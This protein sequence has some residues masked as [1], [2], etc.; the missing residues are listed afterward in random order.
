MLSKGLKAALQSRKAAVDA[1]ASTSEATGDG[2][3]FSASA[4]SFT[5]ARSHGF[6]GLSNLGAT[7]YMNSLLQA[8]FCQANVR[9][10]VLQFAFDEHVQGE[11]KRCVLRQLQWLFS[12]LLLS[13]SAAISTLPLTKSFGWDSSEAFVQND[14]H[15]CLNVLLEAIAREDATVG[16][17]LRDN[18][19]GLL[20]HYIQCEGCGT[21]RTRPEEFTTF[22]IPVKGCADV[23]AALH[24]ALSEEVLSGDNAYS[25][26]TCGSKQ[27][28]RK[29][30]RLPAA[31]LPPT[32]FLHLNR[33]EFDFSTMM[34]RKIQDPIVPALLL[35]M[36]AHA[37]PAAEPTDDASSTSPDSLVYEL[38]G[39]LMHVGSAMS[40]HYFAY[41]RVPAEGGSGEAGSAVSGGGTRWLSFN[42]SI[43]TEL[44][45]DQLARA[46]GQRS[47]AGS[48]SAPASNGPSSLPS[49]F[50]AGTVS[51]GSSGAYLLIYRR[52]DKLSS[53]FE[54]VTASSVPA[55]IRSLIEAENERILEAAA[56]WE[57]EKRKLRF[58]V[59][60][61]G[62]LAA[63]AASTLSSAPSS[64]SP[65]AP[66]PV[67]AAPAI[68]GPRPTMGPR[69]GG[70][71]AV[72]IGSARP[73]LPQPPRPSGPPT[74]PRPPSRPSATA[75]GRGSVAPSVEVV[76]DKEGDASALL[77]AAVIAATG[78]TDIAESELALYCLRQYDV[79]QGVPLQPVIT[80]CSD[81]CTSPLLGLPP[82]FSS[83]PPS[84][85]TDALSRPRA[86]CLEKRASADVAWEAWEG[87]PVPVRVVLV[88]RNGQ[89]QV[90]PV[91]KS[92]GT[93]PLDGFSFS[94]PLLL[95]LRPS[96]ATVGGLRRAVA[97]SQAPAVDVTRLLLAVL[98][99]SSDKSG[100]V[101]SDDSASLLPPSSAS[102][103]AASTAT[104]V[105]ADGAI[106]HAESGGG[107]DGSSSALLHAWEASLHC[108]NVTCIP[109]SASSTS[110][111][112]HQLAPLQVVIDDRQPVTSL[113]EM[114]SEAYGLSPRSFKL[115]RQPPS[116]VPGDSSGCSSSTVPVGELK[117]VSQSIASTGLL[118]GCDV[119]LLPGLA[120]M[121]PGF[122]AIRVSVAPA[123]TQSHDK[124]ALQPLG[125]IEVPSSA[126]ISDIK[127][128]LYR[129]FFETFLQNG[130]S[131]PQHLRVREAPSASGSNSASAS[132]ITSEGDKPAAAAIASLR[133]GKLYAASCTLESAVGGK[134]RLR[135]GMEVVLQPLAQ[136]E[137]TSEG[138][139]LVSIYHWQ[140]ATGQLTGP[141]EVLL[142]HS[143]S[144]AIAAQEQLSG[145]KLLVAESPN[146]AAAADF[147]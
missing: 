27:T 3:R 42:D 136:P 25:C 142:R 5:P 145:A 55:D 81:D 15:E 47:A 121:E 82:L 108:V 21:V 49:S 51:D 102:G 147:W 68:S 35:D 134:G 119:Y 17:V 77:R 97:A 107:S 114:I 143:T 69:P 113:R 16:G 141:S 9:R 54:D 92:I 18:Q 36:S 57:A 30:V 53:W 61:I 11:E 116:I 38:C 100:L 63:S 132:T 28:A 32:L 94:A 26:E 112:D 74:P 87:L 95:Q 129:Q 67:G 43:V 39:M 70:P 103:S 22:M 7:C 124:P 60:P 14:V 37:V 64:L 75:G 88:T 105:L 101:L 83:P 115:C 117:D 99:T 58:R 12:R 106:V 46:L 127:Q 90:N 65:A 130:V 138:D 104:S 59:Y 85:D 123:T 56:K 33:F 13:Q 126:L 109:S 140:P 137:L 133:L 144:G 80:G 110:D 6:A 71:L 86:L 131:S 48:S 1:C 2:S 89:Q 52:R 91:A 125:V 29:G 20:E 79:S 66:R 122:V 40:G 139:G 96:E 76:V 78:A 10:A 62:E 72:S 23:D 8:L 135:D 146:G 41:L 50:S 84:T 120:P 111:S 24:A 118:D 31:Y 19:L 73:S 93:R 128:Q 4:T 45:P 34:R 44:K 98:P